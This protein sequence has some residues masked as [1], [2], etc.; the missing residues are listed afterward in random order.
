M[1]FIWLRKLMAPPVFADEAMTRAAGLLNVVLLILL[2]SSVMIGFLFIFD[3]P[4]YMAA[5]YTLASAVFIA[6]TCL[7]LQFLM[8][9]GYVRTVSILFSGSLWAIVVLSIYIIKGVR[10]NIA[11]FYFVVI[12]VGALLLGK[13]A[14]VIF[15]LLSMLTVLGAYYAEIKGYILYPMPASVDSMD[16]ILLCFA[17]GTGTLLLYFAVHSINEGFELA[18]RSTQALAES[19]RELQASRDTLAQQSQELARSNAELEQ[20]AYVAS[21]DLQEPLRM[22]ASYLKLLKRHYQG[23]LDAEADEFITYAVDGAIRMEALVNDLLKYSRVDIQG[24]PFAPTDCTE[25]LKVALINLQLI[26]EDTGAR[27]FYADLPTVMADE[28]QLIQLFQNLIGNAIKFRGDDPPEIHVAVEYNDRKVY[29]ETDQWLF[30][31]RDN[32]IGLD[33]QQAERIFTIFQRLHTKQ[34]YEGTGIGLAVCKKIVERHG[35]RIWVESKIGKGSIFFF[36][37]PDR[38][39]DVIGEPA[40]EQRILDAL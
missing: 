34:E 35:G 28:I 5:T 15:G 2:V 1:M 23:C 10:N 26:I 20:F 21:H 29:N 8:R 31:V 6:V 11:A 19:N 17:L 24:N 25:V 22:V 16:W 33:P 32:G 3:I 9:R 36:T 30:S 12:A 7:S 37:I 13:R 27:V 38:E 40:V 14:A 39:G 18:H 4:G